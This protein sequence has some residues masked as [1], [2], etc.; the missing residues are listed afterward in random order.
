MAEAALA[1]AGGDKDPAAVK[2]LA[3]ATAEQ[4]AKRAK[5]AP[6]KQQP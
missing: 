1:A 3:E 5:V 6:V 4:W 2:R